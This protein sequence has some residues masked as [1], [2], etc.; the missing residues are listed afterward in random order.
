MSRPTS[1][2]QTILDEEYQAISNFQVFDKKYIDLMVFKLNRYFRRIN[3]FELLYTP[4]AAEDIFVEI[5][6]RK[7]NTIAAQLINQINTL[8]SK[9]TDVQQLGDIETT[10]GK[11]SSNSNNQYQ[12][13]GTSNNTGTDTEG[14]AGYSV[15][16]Q[17]G[18]FRTNKNEAN[19]STSNNSTSNNTSESNQDVNVTRSD[20][21]RYLEHFNKLL[22][23]W[24][25]D[26]VFEVRA[27]IAR[28]VY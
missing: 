20:N 1:Q 13:E 17:D 7:F 19:A 4:E 5:M 18:D 26:V 16:N 23:A 15:S 21:I 2:I 3:D 6:S 28:G 9:W 12:G 10:K 8:N 25:M 14:Y 22:D 27:N 11:L 24:A